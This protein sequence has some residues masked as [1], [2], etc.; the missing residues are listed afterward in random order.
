MRWN[1]LTD[2]RET[3]QAF[4]DAGGDGPSHPHAGAD[5]VLVPALSTDF[6]FHVFLGRSPRTPGWSVV[7]L[8]RD[9]GGYREHAMGFA[10]S[11]YRH[12]VGEEV[13]HP[14]GPG[15]VKLQHLPMGRETVRCPGTALAAEC[16]GCP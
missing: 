2:I 1:L 14:N 12:L 6:G 10:E 9:E 11:P 3:G 13:I 8:D 5:A 7:L 16:E 15:P 4:R